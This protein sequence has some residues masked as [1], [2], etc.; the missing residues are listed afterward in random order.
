[1]QNLSR[2]AKKTI[3][4]FMATILVL[5]CFSSAFGVVA[6]AADDIGVPWDGTTVT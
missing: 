4:V 1:M 6:S 5:S 2:I 3:S